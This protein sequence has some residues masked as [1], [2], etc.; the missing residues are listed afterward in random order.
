V[1]FASIQLLLSWFC[2]LSKSGKKTSVLTWFVG[3]LVKLNFILNHSTLIMISISINDLRR[4][5]VHVAFHSD[6]LHR[7]SMTLKIRPKLVMQGSI[8]RVVGNTPY[9]STPAPKFIVHTIPDATSVCS[10]GR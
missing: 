10:E 8:R 6:I 9:L 4:R 1:V 3:V 7:L 5:F 2:T